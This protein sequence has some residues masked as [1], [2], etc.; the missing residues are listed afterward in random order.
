MLEIKKLQCEYKTNPL[1][2][3]TKTP[4]FSWQLH[5]DRMN[6]YQDS[7][8]IV[9]KK[10]EE[11]V[12]D[13]GRQD[14]Q[15]TYGLHY[16]GKALESKTE[17]CYVLT[18]WDNHGESATETGKFETVLLDRSEWNGKFIEPDKLP[19]L[20]ENPL[21]IAKGKW[22]EFVMKMMNG[23]KAEPIDLDKLMETF[24]PQ[25]YHPAVMMYK[26][27]ALKGQ[28][29]KARLYMTAHGIYE[30]QINGECTSDVQLAPEFTSYDKLLKY[31]VYDVTDSLVKGE[32]AIGVTIA[33][34][35]YKGKVATGKGNDYGDNLALLMELHVT[36]A[37]GSKECI[38]SDEKFLYS[39]E[40]TVRYADL[41]TGEKQDARMKIE[42]FACVDMD[43]SKWKSI[44]VMDYGYEN[45][46]VQ[47]N[48]PIR[49]V[50]ELDVKE[51]MI[52]PQ[53][54]TVIDFGQNF[55]GHI[56]V[57]MQG[58][59]GTEVTFE[60]TE[61]LDKD[62]NFIYPFS[63]TTRE[64]KD[65]YILSG[66]GEEVF[67]PRFTY[68]G[69]RYVRIKVLEGS[70]KKEQFKGVVISSDNE[71]T[72]DFQ[73]SNEKLNR[74]QQNVIWS[75]RSNTIGIPTDCP[76]R[77]K[78]GWTG[79]VVVYG[80]TACFNQNMYKFFEEWLKSVRAEQLPDG[81]VLN[82]VPMI[83][84]YINMSMV[85]SL[86]WGDAVVTLPWELYQIYGDK[87]ILEEN[88]EAMSAWINFVEKT[89][90][91]QLPPEA[92]EMSGRHLENQH[93]L[94]NTGFHF[95]DWLV[96]S[97]VNA[98]GFAD[99]PAS[100]FLTGYTVST[101]L[102]A[103]ITDIMKEVNEL[104]G[105]HDKAEYYNNLGRRIREAFEEEY[106]MD[107]GKL[108]N[109]LQGLYVV[110]LQMNMVKNEKRELL[111]NRLTK[112]VED[113]NNCMDTGFM[114]VPHILDVFSENGKKDMAYKL[115]YQNKCPSWLY[116]VEHGA[117]TMW[118]SWNAI[119]PD[120]KRDGCS[121]NHYA[122]GCV[123]N[124]IYRNILGI[125]NTGIGFEEISICPDFECG[126]EW[127]KGYYDCV[128]GRISID[129]RLEGSKA[130]VEV[131]VPVNVTAQLKI[132]DQ[133]KKVG[134]GNYKF[135]CQL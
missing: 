83:K 37:D 111:L 38:C 135:T 104:I 27:F 92:S 96:P 2:V 98:D 87:Q 66:N 16:L 79:D 88:Y 3:D 109:D 77:E 130:I 40:G 113:N 89:A 63:N 93:Y 58:E 12:W 25:P 105:Y 11:V 14:S 102:F 118:E 15:K 10:E 112:L 20:E 5:S 49:A 17:Y 56:K 39:Y 95:G 99:G 45:L 121:F 48:E 84:S 134:S 35:W 120:G 46:E 67:E 91:E 26:K 62:G 65:I 8:Q 34:G 100:S 116:Q 21:E 103:S 115:L 76:T 133:L 9:V 52:T 86:G 29:Q 108:K 68:H 19:S 119:K 82:T 6:V 33:D 75:Q 129:W 80:K 70:W 55:A 71:I 131:E 36:Y 101:A 61:E 122:F 69:F 54:D 60:H 128:N 32:N 64:Q 18:V 123:G 125:R 90:Y 50:K 110:A 106:L 13:S 31:Q 126:L 114:S 22:M 4:R 28:I 23:E 94:I 30:F 51:I 47:E 107:D 127:A 41:F 85:A 97:V 124:W 72:G 1:T 117:T 132:G 73:C 42:H 59:A 53:G 81:Q 78:A 74:L 24:S 44:N 7:W 57:V 43:T